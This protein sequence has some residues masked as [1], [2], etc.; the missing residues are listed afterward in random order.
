MMGGDRGQTEPSPAS[1]ER[2][3]D[4]AL[5]FG[6]R[7]AL[8]SCA[9]ANVPPLFPGS[10]SGYRRAKTRL[11]HPGPSAAVV[12]THPFALLCGERCRGETEE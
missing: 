8:T 2:H 4:A 9:Y 5:G 12:F 6:E 3:H 1:A 11:S 10:F 7:P